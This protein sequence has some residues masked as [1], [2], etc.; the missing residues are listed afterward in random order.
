M[1][2]DDQYNRVNITLSAENE[3]FIKEMQRKIRI[4]NGRRLPRTKII[5]AVLQVI[6]K[7]KIDFSRIADEND[8]A[9]RIEEAIDQK[10][11]K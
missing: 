10:L 8:L 11:R 7:L 6:K 2:K 5:S 3:D 9:Q 1:N 4:Q